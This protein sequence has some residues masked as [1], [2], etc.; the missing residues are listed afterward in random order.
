MHQEPDRPKRKHVCFAV[1]GVTVAL[2][3][4][5][6][7]PAAW[8]DSSSA[9]ANRPAK[10]LLKLT[11]RIRVIEGSGSVVTPVGVFFTPRVINVG[12]VIIVARNSDPDTAHQLSVNGVVSRPMG[13]G[14]G[15]A[16]MKVTFKRP[17]TY[18]VQVL[19]GTLGLY[20]NSSGL[21][22]VLK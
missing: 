15:T 11:A 6:S 22:K 20:T 17:G 7:A 3:V 14:G 16:V 21:L 19:G 5:G 2:A 12:T 10:P 9:S 18:L 13:P 8:S 1:F 4:L